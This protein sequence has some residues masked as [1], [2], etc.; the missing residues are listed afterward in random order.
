MSDN[1]VPVD[2]AEVPVFTGNLEVLD[3][4]V[5]A[6]YKDGEKLSDKAGDVH[7]TFGGLS[8]YYEAPEA[9]QLFASTLPMVGKADSLHLDV[10]DV[11]SALGTYS[12][13]VNP[14]ADRLD[15]L[16]R[17]A[18]A[19]RAMA[20]AD[21][22]WREDG[23]KVDENN[24]RRTEIAKVWG[25]FMAAEVACQ[26]AIVALVGGTG[27]K[28]NGKPGQE[29]YY[30]Y[31]GDVLS[32]A[33]ELP[34]GKPVEES[35]PWYQSYEY[36]GDFVVGFAVDGVWGTIKGL[37]TLLGFS[38]GDA[39]EQAWIGLG[40]L[41]T[42]LAVMALPGTGAAVAALPDSKFKSWVNDSQK[43]V[44]ETG[45]ALIAY[46]QW[47]TQPGR[48]AGATTFN[49]VT[50]VFTGGATGAAAGAGKAGAIAKTLSLAGKGA[51]VVD[52]MTYVVKGAGLG[53]SKIGNTIA[54]LRGIGNIAI[55]PLPENA[56]ILPDGARLL[57]NGSI[58][59]P[60]GTPVP[61]GAIEL[62]DG[63][64]TAPEGA[65]VVPR[66]AIPVTVKSGTK[67]IDGF[68]LKDGRIVDGRMNTI[69]K[70]DAAPTDIVDR[71][72]A[73]AA[74]GP[75][76]PSPGGTPQLVGGGGR[77]RAPPGDGVP[78]GAARMDLESPTGRGAGSGG[79]VA[80]NA[81]GGGTRAGGGSDDLIRGSSGGHEPPIGGRGTGP[82][83][84]PL[85]DLGRA[86]DDTNPPVHN[87]DNGAG[88]GDNAPQ[89]ARERTPEEQKQIIEEQIRKANDPD[90]SWFEKFYRSDGHR[91]SIK[92]LDENGNA[93]PILA[94]DSNGNWIP[95]DSLPSKPGAK[96]TLDPGSPFTRDSV[97]DGEIGHLDDAAKNRH[98]ANALTDAER[99]FK[100]D[101]SAENLAALNRAQND[102]D[103]AMPGRPN[104]SS[105]AEAL[106]EQA[107]MRH[108]I[109]QA[110]PDAQWIDLPKTPNGANMFDQL[111]RLDDGTL[112]IAEAKA[113]HS[114][115]IWRKGV[116]PGS[117]GWMV[118]Q[119]TRPYVR[120]IIAEMRKNPGLIAKDNLGNTILDSAGRPVTN[121][122]IALQL[123]DALDNGKLK[124]VMVKAAEN[125]GTYAGAKLE[126]FD[127]G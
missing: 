93:L 86:G 30:G 105:I 114:N 8:A 94:K 61:R 12:E 85:D 7:V 112:V 52:P 104:N 59:L 74:G 103:A 120:T 60:D 96:S 111:Y 102:F 48:A 47:D 127:I 27:L 51:R 92:T 34:W 123:M 75:P 79:G 124:Y 118:Q 65:P 58:H 50:T 53:I 1:D 37:G 43:A 9:E 6:L 83:G 41:A 115:P 33:E 40:K 2:P 13:T 26:N 17:E 24:N 49:V 25:D 14:L 88:A 125:P 68:L 84:G 89:A 95:R 54:A 116:G 117:E 70:A 28:M 82:G 57:D 97:P 67:T 46:D 32:Q 113:P 3:A 98:V 122:S 56:V 11:A 90:Q 55:P 80:D 99:V 126:H 69:Q 21:P 29:G 73:R 71:A 121:R 110:F 101:S 22:D 31:T 78:G 10:S 119:G 19:F 87:A 36:G 23:D 16:K 35:V 64:I 91:Q 76:P 77:A 109:P 42:G 106:G 5:K 45:K 81:T 63:R 39:A 15:S 4:K 72:A 38:G 20:A 66:D 107:A 62:P 108:V 18:E 44:V 100:K